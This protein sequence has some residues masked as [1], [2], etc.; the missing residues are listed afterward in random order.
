[1]ENKKWW[2]IRIDLFSFHKPVFIIG[3]I[4]IVYIYYMYKII[5]IKY[6]SMCILVVS[7][8]KHGIEWEKI[9][10]FRFKNAK[11]STCF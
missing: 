8:Y 4:D 2:F 6:K 11:Y 9:I 3:C 1:M 5:L 10:F 7:G